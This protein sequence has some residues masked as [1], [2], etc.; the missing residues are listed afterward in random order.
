MDNAI[1]GMYSRNETPLIPD[2]P[3][4]GHNCMET[5]CMKRQTTC[6]LVLIPLFGLFAEV[7]YVDP[8]HGSISGSGTTTDP[9]KT[10]EDVFD[11]DKIES[12][13]PKNLPHRAGNDLVV[14]NAGAPVQPGDT[15]ML[16]TG[17]HGIIEVTNY[18]NPDYITIMAEP[19][20]SPTAARMEF[21]SSSRWIIRGI[22][23]SP[24]FAEEFSRERMFMF[25]ESRYS[26]P[27][28]DCTVEA[29]TL[30]T[31]RNT[32][33]WSAGDWNRRSCDGINFTG[34]RLRAKNNYIKNVNFGITVNSD[35]CLVEHNIIEN[36]AG[37]G[38]RG[39]GDR[40]TFQYNTIMNCYDVNSNH[41]D[42]FQSWSVGSNGVGTG[43]VRDLI[44]RG[45]M[46]INHID[47]NQ[48]H[49]GRLQGIGCFDGMFEGWIIEN[50]VI[51]VDHYHGVTLRG[52]LNCRIANNTVVHR[53]PG[54]YGPPWIKLDRHKNGTVGHG[55]RV[56]N[57]LITDLR[58][59]PGSGN[60]DHNLEISTRDYHEYFVDSDDFNF[61]LR[62]GCPAVDAGTD[63]LAPTTD[64]EG[65]L[66]PAGGAVDIGAHEYG[67]EAPVSARPENRQNVNL[68]IHSFESGAPR[69]KTQL[70]DVFG[71]RIEEAGTGRILLRRLNDGR[72]KREIS[73]DRPGTGKK[74]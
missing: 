66:R 65:N 71:R 56:L 19:G 6:L 34:T 49:R 11:S 22:T 29:C 10:L 44:L 33:S 64:C 50:N 43:V 30:F 9:W 73:V 18:Y 57:N 36:F 59:V 27:S 38:M 12:R 26:G 68:P 63:D 54:D 62:P 47:P 1:S 35:S 61:Q 69:K 72:V 40:D 53:S 31:V 67:A 15:I 7:F 46:I 52:A 5:M 16:R 23:I 37:D 32:E 17:Y 74:R 70:Y 51:V 25:S 41:D 21:R 13:K 8:S 3:S 20:H 55:N 48:P 60:T 14:R 2:P 24:T 58:L 45:N 4:A 42:G 28:Y 39:L